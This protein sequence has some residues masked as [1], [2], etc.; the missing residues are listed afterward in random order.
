MLDDLS[1]TAA[2]FIAMAHRIVWCSVA[3]VDGQGRP[4]SRVMRPLWEWD[5]QT[6]V[7]W[8]GTTPGPELVHLVSSASVS[9]S[10]WEATQD[11]CIAECRTELVTDDAARARVWN[12]FATAPKPLGYDPAAIGV[13][14]WDAPDAPG[15]V[16]L[17]FRPWRLQVHPLSVLASGGRPE[18]MRTLIWQE[19]RSV[20]MDS[21][22][23]DGEAVLG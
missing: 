18:E 14:G 22:C 2:G 3:T 21:A 11:T 4:H 7:G 17:R 23:E 13:R 6:L 19:V 10:Y 20:A 8:V 1:T 15:F 16:V 12:L 9:C 5:R